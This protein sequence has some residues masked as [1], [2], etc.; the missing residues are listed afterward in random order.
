MIDAFIR[1]I[2]LA[3]SSIVSAFEWRTIMRVIT[4]SLLV[5][6]AVLGMYVSEAQAQP[7]VVARVPFAFTMHGER[8]PAGTYEVREVGSSGDL[9]SIQGAKSGAMAYTFADQS[10]GTDP[11]GDR[12]ALVFNRYENGYRLSEIW[13]S[14]VEGMTLPS[15]GRASKASRASSGTE[16][17]LI[18]GERVQ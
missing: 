13:Q 7:L 4:T 9:L 12:P 8:F 14:G 18:I 11:A 15:T 3:P 17:T 5:A 6:T 16:L 2:C 10:H 1:G